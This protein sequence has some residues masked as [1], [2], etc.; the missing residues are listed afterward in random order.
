LVVK[1]IQIILNVVSKNV[2]E[3]TCNG[4][5]SGWG[6]SMKK[7]VCEFEGPWI[8]NSECMKWLIVRNC[9]VDSGESGGIAH[10]SASLKVHNEKII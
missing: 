5:E 9:W 1:S 2:K 4:G 10:R 3:G 6:T 8:Q 7:K